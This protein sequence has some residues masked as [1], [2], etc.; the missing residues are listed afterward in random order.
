MLLEG[1]FIPLTTPFHPDGRFHPQKLAANVLRYSK[2]PASALIA[3]ASH[4]GEPTLLTDAENAEV[5]RIVGQA[6]SPEKVLL[7]NVSRDSVPATLELAEVAA[8]HGFDA[9]LLQPPTVLTTKHERE[10]ILWFQSIADRSPLPIVLTATSQS[11]S[12]LSSSVIAQLAQHPNICG[13]F[14]G[15]ESLDIA[16]LLAQTKKVSREV[17]VTPTFTAVTSR[18]VRNAAKS[19][20]AE[21]PTALVSAIE[22]ARNPAAAATATAP[23]PTAPALKTRTRRIGFQVVISE[24]NHLLASLRFGASAIAPA[25]AACAPQACYEVYAAWKDGDQP[26]AD[27]KQQRVLSA[28]TLADA[29]GPPALKHGCDLNGYYGGPARLPW[30][31]LSVADRRELETL[32][33]PLRT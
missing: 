24:P 13:L 8:L 14:S 6:S 17:T 18:M 28:A 11:S 10:L 32:M 26:L 4:V 30:L 7:A 33:H 31:P 12:R 1:L 2:S 27:E 19:A 23:P 3:L 21:P 22:L 9:I 20:S 29:L 25:F 16:D 5:L 15:Q